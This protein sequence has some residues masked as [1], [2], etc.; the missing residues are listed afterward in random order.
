MDSRGSIVA[1]GPKTRI[2]LWR[3][4]RAQSALH[5]GQR[6]VLELQP[7]R[8]VLDPIRGHQCCFPSNTQIRKVQE[9]SDQ[10]LLPILSALELES[11]LLSICSLQGLCGL[12]IPWN[13]LLTRLVLT[14]VD[15]KDCRDCERSTWVSCHAGGSI[16]S[17]TF[18][19]GIV[20]S[21]TTKYFLTL[22]PKIR[23]CFP[24]RI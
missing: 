10:R 1:L 17:G 3:T 15:A 19:G 4:G 20:P 8:S 2:C 18:S 24:P 14:P 7:F 13:H 21:S 9:V 16:G 23:K 5:G 12:A 6:K 22:V 11:L